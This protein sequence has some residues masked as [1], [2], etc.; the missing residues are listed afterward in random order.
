MLRQEDIE[1]YR[2]MTAEEKVQQWRA[3]VRQ[4]WKLLDVPDA[5]TGRRK[6][7]AWER[8][9]ARANENILRTLHER[10]T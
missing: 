6:W 9:H 7:E 4:G 2:R 1:A 5:E 3:L 10:D 8:E